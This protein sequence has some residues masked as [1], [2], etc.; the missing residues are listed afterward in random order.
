MHVVTIEVPHLG[1]RSYLVHDGRVG[2]VID[3][4]HDL[5][6]SRPQPMPVSTSSRSRRRTSTTTTSPVA[7]T[8]KRHRAAYLLAEG[9]EVARTDRC[10]RQRD[11]RVRRHRSRVIATPGHTPLHLSTW[12]RRDGGDSPQRILE[13]WPHVCSRRAWD[14]APHRGGAGGA[15]TRRGRPGTRGGGATSAGGRGGGGWECWWRTSRSWPTRATRPPGGSSDWLVVAMAG[16]AY[17]MTNGRRTQ[18]EA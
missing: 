18:R 8:R 11:P 17:G 10:L 12:H 13:R 2:V 9:E 7:T 14:S 5:R 1:N 15:R 3:A 6:R 16:F 4:P